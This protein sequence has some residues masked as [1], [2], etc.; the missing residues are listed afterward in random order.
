M[1]AST[2][3]LRYHAGNGSGRTRHALL[4]QASL[5]AGG[6][7]GLVHR[8]DADEDEFLAPVAPH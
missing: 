6:Q 5:E 7:F 4:H 1:P 3:P 2:V 8:F